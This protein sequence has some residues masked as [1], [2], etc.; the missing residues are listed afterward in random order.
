MKTGESGTTFI[1]GTGLN[2]TGFDLSAYTKL[3]L[4]FTLPNG[5][6]LTVTTPT[7]TLGITAIPVPGGTLNSHQYVSCVLQPGQVSVA[8]VW[9]VRLIYDQNTATPP[10]H[11]SSATEKFIVA[12]VALGQVQGPPIPPVV[13][14]PISPVSAASHAGSGGIQ[15]AS[16]TSVSIPLFNVSTSGNAG[17]IVVLAPITVSLIAASA[18]AAA[19]TSGVHTSDASNVS[20]PLF[21]TGV[22]GNVSSPTASALSVVLPRAVATGSAGI[23]GVHVSG[24]S[25]VSVPLFGVSISSNAVVL[26]VG[27][28]GPQLTTMTLINTSGSTQTSGFITPIF[29]MTFKKGDVPIN[30]APKFQIGGI[31]QPYSWGLQS[32]YSDGSLRHASFMFRCSSSIAGNGTLTVNINSGG[33]APSASS[34]TLTEV[35][36]QNLQVGGP[37]LGL[38]GG[39]VGTWNGYLRNDAN[40]TEQ[41]VYLDGQAGKSWRIK[42]HMAQSAGGTAHGQLEVY[43]YVT[44]LQDNSG[45]LGGFRHIARITQPYY[46]L[47]TPTKALRAFSSI[48]TQ[49]GAGPT[50]IPL[51]W[52]FTN[53]NFTTVNGSMA[54]TVA[55]AGTHNFYSGAQ[56]GNGSDCVNCVPGYLSAT[57][58]GALS[59]G[60][61]YFAFTYGA[62][63]NN[64]Y[65]QLSVNNYGLTG[66]ISLAGGTGTFVPVPVVLHGLSVYTA[67]SQG[68][69]NF[70][71]GTGSMSADNTMRTQFNQAYLHSTG[72]IPPWNLTLQGVAFS[73]TVKDIPA[74]VTSSSSSYWMGSPTWNPVTCGPLAQSWR[75]GPGNVPDI[76]PLPTWACCHF[77]NQTAVSDMAI[78]SIAFAS[79]FD[80]SGSVRDV[81]TGNYI[82]ITN[83]SYSGMPAP[84]SNQQTGVMIVASLVEGF[85]PAST[86]TYGNQSF[87]WGAGEQAA[88][89][90]SHRPSSA[91]YAFLIFGEPH[92]HDLMI[93]A[94]TGD[95]LENYGP[96]RVPSSPAG[97]G[98]IATYSEY[99]LRGT[100]W[101]LRDVMLAANFCAATSP[102]GSAIPTYLNDLVSTN[103]TY[104]NALF[105]STYIGTALAA[106]NSW[107]K[108]TLN[109]SAV[110]EADGGFMMGYF[111]CVMG[112]LATLGNAAAKT[113]CNNYSTWLNY[114][115]STWGGYNLYAE[116]DGATLLPASTTP[117]GP[118]TSL[119]Q[120]GI[121]AGIYGSL[122]W[123]S[124]GARAFTA[125]G[126]QFGY[127]VT[128]GDRWVFMADQGVPG[129]F[130]IATIPIMQ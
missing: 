119:T 23:S 124:A 54:A 77:Y 125:N 58:D 21:G 46:N 40:N 15:I 117:A 112:W 68:R 122:T 2:G 128:A 22:S 7:V 72:A 55:S 76:G 85:T 84:S 116:Y 26:G 80:G 73:G 121:T 87:L 67:D 83:T 47:D 129:G 66:A 52:P 127:V 8:G 12:T 89:D 32:Y 71:Q 43:Q 37:G 94:A 103:M 19:G 93:E 88:Q 75:G 99:G 101:A 1:V 29:G 42:T 13:R 48:S 70:F 17:A 14:V 56:P 118:I 9:Q 53:T 50:S 95:T 82:N 105:S 30:T 4:I 102:D 130:S 33:T 10:I 3:T 45:N 107:R 74:I 115:I 41:Y 24:S 92:F 96:N 81:S 11:F 79:D 49:Y 109:G 31:D 126:P 78:R 100:A 16:S 98:I 57:T 28:A 110:D 6:I 59:T 44:A 51:T 90:P 5:T 63:N 34:R 97:Y 91:F 64:T 65:F 113:W 114:V 123:R 120:Y 62:A 25:S 35:Y 111:E 20:V 69:S 86:P 27:P 39:L 60:Q 18:V 106:Q 104:I 108:V 36:A 61:V 38:F